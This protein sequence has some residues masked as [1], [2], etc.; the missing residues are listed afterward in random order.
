M[1]YTTTEIKEIESLRARGVNEAD[2]FHTLSPRHDLPSL[3][4]LPSSALE[5]RNANYDVQLS[6][7]AARKEG[8]VEMA[9]KG[10]GLWD[11]RRGKE[12]AEEERK[13]VVRGRVRGMPIGEFCVSL[14]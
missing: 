14:Q 6:A 10:L 2:I 12:K 7:L 11:R 4:S 9:G 8:W 13:L 1:P 5:H 3:R